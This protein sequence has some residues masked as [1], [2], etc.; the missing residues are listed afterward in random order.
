MRKAAVPLLRV[1]DWDRPYEN[2]RSRDLD[3]T[4]WVP[5][6]NDL[7]EDTY[8]ELVS[9][10][11][12]A[13]HL[14]VW[15]AVLMV[16]SRSRPRG[17][18]M[19]EDGREHTAESLSLLTR[20]AKPIVETAIERLLTIGLLETRA[21][22]PR[23]KNQLASHPSAARSHAGAAG[24]HQDAVEGKGIEH[25]HQEGKG[26]EK[27]RTRKESKEPERAKDEPPAAQ[28][29]AREAFPETPFHE[30]DDSDEPPGVR[31]ASPEDEL[32]AIYLAKS[33]EPITVVLLDAIRSNLEVT[34]IALADFVAEVRKH[35]RGDWRNP[36]GFLRDLSKRFRLK[37]L[38]ASAPISAAEALVRD[39]RCP[40]CFSRTPGQGAIVD[41]GLSV[42]C[43]CASA[44]W[45][46]ELRFR[47][48]FP[49]EERQ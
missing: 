45:V 5:M 41:G 9:H 18:L 21:S 28:S 27:K 36:A 48:V 2:N 8:V 10:G 6:P 22:K 11:D 23:V 29:G 19:R 35:V 26:T 42:P 37:T 15:H 4:S 32:K 1:H 47:R 44:D 13:A 38:T 16:A 31:Y 43:A 12:G 34:R 7:A 39:Y 24:S 49:P 3:R 17:V 20:L 30:G 25:H 40:I 14:G 46:A 33:G